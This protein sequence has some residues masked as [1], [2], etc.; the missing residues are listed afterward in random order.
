MFCGPGAVVQSLQHCGS[1]AGELRFHFLYGCFNAGDILNIH[2]RNI[3]KCSNVL[4]RFYS[5]N[6]NLTAEQIT[7]QSFMHRT[8]FINGDLYINKCV[9]VCV[10]GS[11]SGAGE[12]ERS[13]GLCRSSEGLGCSDAQ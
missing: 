11:K 5:Y 2:T 10:T 4:S 8:I 13:A 7:A 6:H 1:K 12:R 9:C 3:I